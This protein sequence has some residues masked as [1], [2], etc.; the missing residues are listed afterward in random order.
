MAQTQQSLRR[1]DLT[2]TGW[3][4]AAIADGDEWATLT[5]AITVADFRRREGA[6][7]HT[8]DLG[9]DAQPPR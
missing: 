6:P 3:E 1:Y 7:F 9:R 8:A 4:K 2:D 5:W